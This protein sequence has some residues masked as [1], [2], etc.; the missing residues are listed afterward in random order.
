MNR[1]AWL[2]RRRTPGTLTVTLTADTRAFTTAMRDAADATRENQSWAR[3]HLRVAH[4][5][6]LGLAHVNQLLDQFAR[7]V[8]VAGRG[9][10]GQ[11]RQCSLGSGEC[12]C[13][14][15]VAAELATGD[16]R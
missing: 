7:D 8:G 16:S 9:H 2:R 1:P 13:G 12:A 4:E 11:E 14:R 15:E 5:R 3:Y 6:R 10:C